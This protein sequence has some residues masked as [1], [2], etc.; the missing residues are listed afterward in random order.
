[1]LK[2]YQFKLS[3]N[4]DQIRPIGQ[5]QI[6]KYLKNQRVAYNASTNAEL[7]SKYCRQY[8]DIA[9]HQ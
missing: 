6:C 5:R 9:Y 2:T 8:K 4:A 7:L 3:E 1:M